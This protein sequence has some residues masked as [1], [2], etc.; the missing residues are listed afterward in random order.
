MVD[1]F[2]SSIVAS[3]LPTSTIHHLPDGVVASSWNDWLGSLD[4]HSSPSILTLPTCVLRRSP[5]ILTRP[6][7]KQVQGE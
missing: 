1:F 4:Q 7:S 5:H 3:V 2:L 6:V